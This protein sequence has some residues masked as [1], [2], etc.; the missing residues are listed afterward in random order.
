MC[1]AP[2]LNKPQL[3]IMAMVTVITM[4]MKMITKTE[5]KGNSAQWRQPCCGGGGGEK[6]GCSYA[7]SFAREKVIR[8]VKYVAH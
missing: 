8:P 7:C 5:T 2:A 4:T 6:D 3:A 1:G